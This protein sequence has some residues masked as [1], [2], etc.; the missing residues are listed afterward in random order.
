LPKRLA[1]DQVLEIVKSAQAGISIAQIAKRLYLHKTTVYYHARSYCRKMTRLDL[2]LLTSVDKGYLVGFFLGD[3][4]FNSGRKTPRYIV[5][6]AL[7]AK[8]DQDIASRL[9]Q[10]FE[11]AC[12][13]VSIFPEENTLIVKVCSKELVK[14]LQ[15]YVEYKVDKNNQ[16]E[17]KIIVG[18]DQSSNFQYGLLAGI[19]DS[20]GHVHKHLGAEIKTVSPSTFK[21]ILNLLNSLGIVAKTKRRKAT[22]NSY[23]KKDCYT[24]YIPSLQMR[25]YE[26]KIPSVKIKRFF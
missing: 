18:K 5:R 14:F 12:K 3:G 15:M 20:D 17:K 2:N 13:K 11:K 25:T 1:H 24:I 19:I 10:I 21:S 23:S 6:F 16:K 7:D 8:R 22:E 9:A 4:S 26:D